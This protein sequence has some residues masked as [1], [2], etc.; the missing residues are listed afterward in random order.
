MISSNPEKKDF[1]QPAKI[2]YFCRECKKAI[3][4]VRVGKKFQFK[5]LECKNK[6]VAFGTQKSIGNYYH[7]EG[8]NKNAADEPDEKAKKIFKSFDEYHGSLN[9]EIRG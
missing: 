4:P 6:S 9:Q 8:T 5:C 7:L 2:I 1:F 3:Q